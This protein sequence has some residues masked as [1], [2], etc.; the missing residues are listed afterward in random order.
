MIRSCRGLL[1]GLGFLTLCQS[2]RAQDKDLAL[3]LRGGTLIDGTGSAPRS[4]VLILVRNGKIEAVGKDVKIPADARTIDVTGKF[5]IPALIDLRVRIGPTPGNHT[6]RNEVEA[7]QRL[8]SLRAL[9]AAGVSTARLE[10]GDLA[11]QQL[12]QRWW[13]ED[14]LVSPRLATSGPVFTAKFG[15]PLEEYSILA[16]NIRDRE[17][18]QI[19]N[20]D[21]AREDAREVAHAGANSFEINADQGPTSAKRDR[22]GKPL[23]GILVTEAHGHDL[24]VFCEV[25][26]NQEVLDAVTVGVNTVEGIWEETLSDEATAALAKG[27]V[28]FMPSL[29][30]QGDLLNLLDEAQLK[31]YLEQPIVQQSLSSIM[32]QGLAN[33]S[34]MVQRLRN[35]LAGEGGE[36]I[37]RQLEEQQ[38]RAFANVRK[39]KAAGVKLAVGTGAGNLLIFPGASVHRELQ[40]LVKAGLTPMEAIVAATRNS[41]ESL[42]LGDELGTIEPGKAAD[43]V[44]LDADPL[45]DIR[46]TQRIHAVIQR[47]REVRPQDLQLR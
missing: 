39:A 9:L 14:V 11:E 4:D 28:T 38:I 7:E 6:S 40:L 22:L 17:L 32:K 27:K 45:V 18:R 25:G 16:S 3:I 36:S 34:G 15:H 10:Q 47:G 13:G 24:P 26:W 37:R 44:I 19:A 5:I 31:D 12:Y 23:L 21:Q 33:H 2:V 29:T 46:N 8:E 20:E 1:L 35:N 43:F 41:S 30:Q 42:G